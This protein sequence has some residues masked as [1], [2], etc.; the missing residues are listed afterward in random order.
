MATPQLAIRDRT[1][2]ARDVRMMGTRAPSTR[3]ALS[4]LARK[5]SSL[6]KMLPASRSGA[7]SMSGSPA[8]SERIPFVLAASL[9]MA[10]LKA[11]GR[12]PL[13]RELAFALRNQSHR[14]GGRSTAIRSVDDLCSPEVDAGRFRD[15]GDLTN[16]ADENRVDQPFTAGLDRTGQGRFLT[17]VCHRCWN[18]LKAFALQQQLFVLSCS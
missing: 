10:L 12:A 1:L 13:Q 6:A 11:V 9:L 3:P 16:R 7:R 18:R 8:T 2:S 17:W 4:A 15:P 14:H 5:L